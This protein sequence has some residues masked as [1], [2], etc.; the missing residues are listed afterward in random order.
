MRRELGRLLRR[1]ANKLDP[2]RAAMII[3]P[4]GQ[5]S[6]TGTIATFKFRGTTYGSGEK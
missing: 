4:D 1:L 6:T 5:T 2:P 3:W